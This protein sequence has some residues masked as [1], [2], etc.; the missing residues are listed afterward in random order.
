MHKFLQK[1]ADKDAFQNFEQKIQ[2]LAQIM[3]LP[4]D[5]GEI[6]HLAVRVNDEKTAKENLALFL[7]EGQILSQNQVNGR[8]IYLI[9]LKQSLPICGQKVRIIELPFPKKHYAKTGWEHIE[10]VLPFLAQE[11]VEAWISRILRQFSWQENPSLK[12]KISQP[13]ATGEQLANP[14][15]AVSLLDKSQNHCCIKV[16]P[17]SIRQIVA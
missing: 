9:Q 8:V 3:Q 10:M 15:I 13:E 12:V 2:Q 6:D 17:Y 1:S 11:S 14:T 5:L 4:L 16:H 7:E